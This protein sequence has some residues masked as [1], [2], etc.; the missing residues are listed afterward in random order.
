MPKFAVG[1]YVERI[2]SLVP[3]YMRSG[4]IIR[5]IPNDQG[6]DLFNEYEVNFGNQV[7]AIFYENQL[8]LA[9]N[10]P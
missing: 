1:D 4:V 6:L 9:T 10:N 3:E 7:I 5:V 2:G 8:R